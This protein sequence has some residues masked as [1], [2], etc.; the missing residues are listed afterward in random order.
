MPVTPAAALWCL[1][2]RLMLP[3]SSS[4]RSLLLFDVSLQPSYEH[5]AASCHC[6]LAPGSRAGSLAPAELLKA[7]QRQRAASPVSPPHPPHTPFPAPSWPH[8]RSP[9]QV[10]PPPPGNR[11]LPPFLSRFTRTDSG[12]IG[13]LPLTVLITHASIFLFFFKKDHLLAGY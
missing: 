4:S 8:G 5:K 13:P 11:A 1:C 9:R 3:S 2:C 10:C 7:K 12:N 6:D